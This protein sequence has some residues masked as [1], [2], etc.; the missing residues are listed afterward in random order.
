MFIQIENFDKSPIAIDVEL[1]ALR[2][3][4]GLIQPLQAVKFLKKTN[5]TGNIKFII[6]EINKL[7]VDE[8]WYFKSFVLSAIERREHT[9]SVYEALKALAIEYDYLDEF[10]KADSAKKMYKPSDCQ[11]HLV[12]NDLDKLAEYIKEGKRCVVVFGAKQSKIDL[13][14][15][16]LKNVVQ[17]HF[18]SS[19]VCFDSV[20]NIPPYTDLSDCRYVEFGECDLSQFD[21]L[22]FRE[23]SVVKF[24]R[25]YNFPDTLNVTNCGTVSFENC[26]ISNLPSITIS[27]SAKFN[28]VVLPKAI[29]LSPTGS[30]VFDGCDFSTVDELTYSSKLLGAQEITFIK[31]RNL[32]KVLDLSKYGHFKFVETDL[33]GVE[34][35]KFKPGR[36]ID[37][38]GAY[39]YPEVLSFPPLDFL[40]DVCMNGVDL[41]GVKELRFSEKSSVEMRGVK[42]V[43]EVLDF[44]NCY[45]VDLS[46]ANLAGV[47]NIKFGKGST[48]FLFDAKNLPSYLDFSECELVYIND[49]AL[50][51][52]ESIKFANRY[53]RNNILKEVNFK[54]QEIFNKNI[55]NFM[56]KIGLFR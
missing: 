54:G 8:R 33:S 18:D 22:S 30:A 52:V 24:N 29:Y 7:S 11:L 35:I 44:S 40:E 26:D 51:E 36:R 46:G 1:K 39:N 21:N 3:E 31:C 10:I 5:H 14:G 9:P 27:H 48:V 45:R 12:D 19:R 13:L 34:E 6:K 25:D 43:P 28:N 20:K 17:L 42:N 23:T 4:Y 49:V 47:K 53:Q 38:I 32:P 50:K 2:K 55:C 16:D 41:K 37:L 15:F 56:S